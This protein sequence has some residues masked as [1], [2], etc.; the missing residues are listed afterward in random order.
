MLLKK[1]LIFNHFSFS[2]FEKR[3]YIPLPEA[4]ARSDM[5]KLAI[6]DTPHSLTAKD[7]HDLG[8][9]TD[10]Y[11]GADINILVRDALM[12]PVRKVQT[13]THFRLFINDSI[14]KLVDS[15]ICCYVV[16]ALQ[17]KRIEMLTF[18][19]LTHF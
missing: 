5:F 2:R 18:C 15:S 13:A 3:I 7:L 9:M 16:T 6:G 11:S 12:Q 10:G 4:P 14:F 8:K 17:I 19:K 1:I